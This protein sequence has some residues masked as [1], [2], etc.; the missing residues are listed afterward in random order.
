MA[1]MMT[2][3][4]SPAGLCIGYQDG[5]A[6]LLG[7]WLLCRKESTAA[8]SAA[9]GCLCVLALLWVALYA[10]V[11]AHV[12][13]L[14]SRIER[15]FVGALSPKQSLQLSSIAV[16]LPALHALLA[17]AG[18]V[19][20][21]RLHSDASSSSFEEKTP[22][23]PSFANAADGA[24]FWTPP[25]AKGCV[26]AEALLAEAAQRTVEHRR[27]QQAQPRRKDPSAAKERR[28]QHNAEAAVVHEPFR[29]ILSTTPKPCWPGRVKKEG[30]GTSSG[31]SS[32]T[33]PSTS[34]SLTS[35]GSGALESSCCPSEASDSAFAGAAEPAGDGN[36]LG[37]SLQ[38]LGGSLVE[39]ARGRACQAPSSPATTDTESVI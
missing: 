37:G 33:I 36:K 14:D 34:G 17:L 5:A 6:F 3:L 9:Y 23:L 39:A 2:R 11:L 10:Y 26:Q 13:Q 12:G 32:P 4:Y 31:S 18:A 16:S 7:C 28:E 29:A 20:A 27:K 38:L 24:A 25:A 8:V 1:G 35:C 22:L 19:V 15:L 21:Q 30:A